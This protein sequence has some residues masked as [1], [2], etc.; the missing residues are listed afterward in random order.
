M[1]QKKARLTPAKNS[2]CS[3]CKAQ[4]HAIPNTPHRRCSGN[5]ENISQELNMQIAQLGGVAPKAMRG[6]WL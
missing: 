6:V 1:A 4:A 5:S 3:N 2:A